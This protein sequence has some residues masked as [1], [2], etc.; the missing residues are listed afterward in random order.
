MKTELITKTE[1]QISLAGL[2]KVLLEGDLSKLSEKEC[3]I[4]YRKVCE[5]L[6]LNPLTKPFEY[7][8]LNGKKILYTRRDA[9]DQLRKNHR[10]SII[11]PEK[12]YINGKLYQVTAQAKTPDGRTDESTG[13]V[14]IEGLSGD[15]LAN[16]LM[17]AETKAKRRVTLSICGLGFLDETEIETI[18]QATKVPYK[19][20]NT[21][22]VEKIQGNLLNLTSD[23]H[24][25]LRDDY[26]DQIRKQN[27]IQ[28]KCEGDDYVILAGKYKGK[29]IQEAIMGQKGGETE[30]AKFDEFMQWLNK[31][32]PHGKN[33]ICQEDLEHINKFLHP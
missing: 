1:E 8:Y 30:A 16:A 26:D 2:E 14:S 11:L 10:L 15:K 28:E 4:Y 32:G 9:T 18:P 23:D 25:E 33:I 3:L 6:Q 27:Q 19:P 12:N 20:S 29:T 22:L 13:V 21:E 24:K 7:L 31:Y 5:S 17:K